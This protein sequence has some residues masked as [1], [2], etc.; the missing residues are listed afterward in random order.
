MNRIVSK[1]I[2]LQVLNPTSLLTVWSKIWKI[3][4]AEIQP[5]STQAIPGIE[6]YGIRPLH[7]CG[8]DRCQGLIDSKVGDVCKWDPL[9]K[10]LTVVK[11]TASIKM[12]EI[13]PFHM[14]ETSFTCLLAIIWIHKSYSWPKGLRSCLRLPCADCLH[15]FIIMPYALLILCFT[16]VRID[17]VKPYFQRMKPR[18]EG[19]LQEYIMYWYL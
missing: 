15:F 13:I 16:F 6:I 1:E 11:V 18:R 10:M 4:P 3:A 17:S 12:C 2:G 5:V 14:K 7:L 9:N 19:N 8:P